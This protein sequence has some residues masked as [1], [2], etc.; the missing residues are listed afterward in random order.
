MANAARQPEEQPDSPAIITPCHSQDRIISPVAGA[1][2]AW[3]RLSPLEKAFAKGQLAGG[4]HRYTA[5]QRF[6]AGQNYAQ[7]FLATQTSGRDS[8]QSL[9]V[10][11]STGGGCMAQTQANAFAMLRTLEASMK[12]RD[13]LIIHSVCGEGEVPAEA[14]RLICGDYRDTIA[15]RFREALDSLV[16]AFEESRPKPRR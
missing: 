14:I 15:A 7:I 13:R 16:E 11:R 3:R 4:G 1:P 10:S 9:N 12:C 5:N 2:R 6:E 8:T